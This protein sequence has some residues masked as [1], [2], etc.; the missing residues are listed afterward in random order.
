M[1]T[2]TYNFGEYA[3]IEVN[4]ETELITCTC[5]EVDPHGEMYIADGDLLPCVVTRWVAAHYPPP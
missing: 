3:T 4:I 2:V 5:P 1:S